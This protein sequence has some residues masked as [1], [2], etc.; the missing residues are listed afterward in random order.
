MNNALLSVIINTYPPKA[1]YLKESIEGLLSQTFKSFEIIVINDGFD[2]ETADII[3]SYSKIFPITYNF[4][5]NDA[6]VSR[7]RNIGARLAKTDIL[8]FIDSDIIL[9]PNALETYYKY[10]KDE[11]NLS[12]WGKYGELK[13]DSLE[14]NCENI[15]DDRMIFFVNDKAREYLE[16]YN[17]YTP[18]G[19]K[20][21]LISTSANF[22]I[23]KELFFKVNGFSEAYRGWGHED[24]N[25]GY[26]LYKQN[27]KFKFVKE[28]WGLHLAH[29]KNGLFYE[30][31]LIS[32]NEERL[33]IFLGEEYAQ[34]LSLNDELVIK[35]HEKLFYL[36]PRTELISHKILINY[37]LHKNSIEKI[38]KYCQK[39]KIIW[40]RIINQQ[41][42][43]EILIEK[44]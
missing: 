15:F 17:I 44:L 35:E 27:V 5:K 28:S 18:Y 40:K 33:N 13:Q 8:I 42:F 31:K 6:Y 23:S 34:Y 10:L 19:F 14:I 30:N 39:H 22:G 12:V 32:K 7:S 24:I 38:N 29:E 36:D 16:N 2:K 43:E 41:N 4:R 11:N 9:N 25:F 21:F 37:L 20:V 3:N 1:K 26:K